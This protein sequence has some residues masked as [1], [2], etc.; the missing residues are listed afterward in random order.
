MAENGNSIH[1]SIPLFKGEN[2]EFWQIKMTTLFKSQGLWDLVD[3]GAGTDA[4]SQKKDAKALFFLQQA[5]HESIFSKIAVAT[6][7][8]VAW[9]TLKTAYQGTS[10]VMAI[11]LQGLRREFETLLMKPEEKVQMFLTRVNTTVNQIK[12]CGETIKEET[13]VAKVLRSLTPKFDHVVAAIEESKD[14]STYTF[15][16]LM[17]SLQTHEVRL[18]RSSEGSDQGVFFTKGATSGGRGGNSSRGRGRG[19]SRGGRGRGRGG[20]GRGQN[21]D[22]ENK[23]QQSEKKDKK[24]V[25]CF[26][27]KR[28]GHYQSECYRKTKE[29]DGQEDVQCYYCHKYGHVQANCY[30]KQREEGQASYAETDQHQSKLFMAYT[31]EEVDSSSIWF[32]DSGCS[33]HMTCHK[34]LFEDLDTSHKLKVRLGDD[35]SIQVEGKGTIAVR[36]NNS[37]MKYLHNVYFIPQ[38]SQNLLSIG[39]LMESGYSILFEGSTCLIKES[40]T[41]KLIAEVTMATNKLFPLEISGVREKALA[42]KEL[43]Q[44]ELWHLRYG[45]LYVKGLKLLNQKQMVYGLPEI[46][47][48]GVCEGC[49]YGKQAKLPFPKGLAKRATQ[50]L[51]I[52]HTDLCGPMETT[53]LGGSKYFL[54]FIDDF[55]R[56]N[57]VYF[58]QNKGETFEHFKKFKAYAEKQSEKKLKVLRSDRGGEYQSIEFQKF[59][60]AEGIHHEL[61]VPYTPE[62]NGV[63]ERKNRTIVEMARSMLKTKGLPN[64]FWAEAVAT[65]VYLLNLSPTKAVMN[66]T[67]FEAWFERKPAIGHLKVFGCIAY[68][69][70]NSQSRKKLDEKSE[71]CIFI[72]YCTQSKGYRLYNPNSKKFIVSRN[73]L[74]DENACWN[75]KEKTSECEVEFP[76]EDEEGEVQ[77]EMQMQQQMS[78]NSDNTSTS[79]ARLSD[80]VLVDPEDEGRKFRSI[81]ELY[82]AT[83]ILYVADPTTYEEA[84]EKKEW[85]QAMQEELAAIERNNTWK[86]VQLPQGKNVIGVK[87]V[88]KTKY[89][90]DGTINKYKARLVVKGYAQKYGLDFEETFSPVARFET[91]RMILSLAAQMKKHVY[92]LDVKSA[93]LNG[94]LN[95][96]VYVEQPEGFKKKG[97]ENWVYKLTK[98][99]YGL[100]QAPRAWYSKIDSCFI[101]SGFERSKSEPNLYVKKEG[102][103]L[104]ILCL[105]VDD[106][107]YFGTDEGLV[108]QFKNNMK[109]QFEMTDLGLLHYFLGLEVK[110]LSGKIFLSQ[111][112]YASDM[113]YKFGMQGCKPCPTPMNKNEKLLKEDGSGAADSAKYRSLVGCLIYLTHTRPDISYAVGVIS[114]FMQTPTNHHYGAAKRVLRYVAG[115]L[116]FGIWYD[117]SS[118]FVLTGFSD[119]DWAGCADDCKSTTGYM[120][121]MGSGAVSWCS[122]KQFSVAL[123]SSEAEY[124]AISSTACQAVW[125]RRILSDLYQPQQQSTTI[126]CDNQSAI[127]MTK[128][129]VFHG[130]TKHIDIR[131]HF[132]RELVSRQQVQLQHIKTDEQVADV[133]TK[134]LDRGKFEYF[135]EMLGVKSFESRGSVRD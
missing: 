91:V 7:A 113:L 10:R 35:K 129:P 73:V 77:E 59:C 14:L 44:S 41:N 53:S 46:D 96:E 92:Q 6:S 131:V 43:N 19:N 119:S 67:P 87:W 122:K 123:S 127:A 64:L 132:I 74:F 89:G 55:S 3:K 98:A 75:W 16:E 31:K 79:T 97:K 101:K 94:D 109:K 45:H 90:A 99:L 60:E 57:W 76:T 81:H 86:L 118:D 56:M 1:P 100:K 17:G 50:V 78:S 61:T 115:T 82:E 32:L 83:Q 120:F 18:S 24:D 37:G 95:E 72:G 84:S 135:R 134:A 27:F 20:Y 49:I 130:R 26:N 103:K 25:Q 4:E 13:I 71:K 66:K 104:L 28:Y 39:Q 21:Q 22:V 128:N 69:L 47:Q 23:N 68:T 9:N 80:N 42:M 93:F 52:V 65:A 133:L 116:N 112:K 107:I 111:K 8:Q 48:L 30:Q 12:S 51:E 36:N 106:M 117:H 29:E 54:L 125:L 114:R 38:L 105:Y 124:V 58:L 2:Y 33:N 34:H 63:A 11:K 70:V 40:E 5:V 110:Q 102:D 121:T 88:F 85:C 62:Q 126:L 108:E 15:D